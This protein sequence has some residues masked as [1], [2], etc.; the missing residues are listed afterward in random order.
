MKKPHDLVGGYFRKMVGLAGLP[1]AMPRCAAR[2]RAGSRS[3]LLRSN[4]CFAGVLI[5]PAAQ[6]VAAS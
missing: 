5:P 3:S 1:L 4:L 2:L 6:G